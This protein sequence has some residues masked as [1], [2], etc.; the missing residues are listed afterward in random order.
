MIPLRLSLRN[1]MCFREG[2]PPLSFEGLHLLCLSGNNGN[3]KTALID[4]M[5]WALWGEA[6][7]KNPD[8]LIS[9]SQPEMEVDFE[10]A[11][12]ERTYRIIRKRARPRSQKASGV[13]TLDFQAATSGSYKSIAGNT[14]A[15]TQ[16]K[17]TD[18]L[19]MDYQTFT[20]SAYLRQGN[21]DEFTNKR[22]GERKEV[23][24]SIL[25]LSR[26]D[27][28]SEQAREQERRHKAE[29][30]QLQNAV[31]ELSDEIARKPEYE[32]ELKQSQDILNG[33]ETEMTVKTR[34]LEELRQRMETLG[35]MQVE[36]EQVES[37]M[38][39]TRG[40][41]E[42]WKEQARLRQS[43]IAAYREVIS[44]KN[45]IEEGF[46]RFS[47]AKEQFRNL[48]NKFRQSFNLERQKTQLEVKINEASRKLNNE[49]IILQREIDK[50]TEQS[51]GLQPLLNR[52]QSLR[53]KQ[54]GF[55]SREQSIREKE[56]EC[57]DFQGQ[58][59]R[60][61]AENA[62]LEEEIRELDEKLDLL[63]AKTEARCPLCET[64][65]GSEGLSIIR[66]KYES[67]RRVKAASLE[68]NL[69]TIGDSRSRLDTLREEAAGLQKA[70]G[71]ERLLLEG[72]IRVLD[73]NIRE[74]EDA[75]RKLEEARTLLSDIEQRLAGREYA[76]ADITALEEVTAAIS[77]L[78]YDE[79]EHKQAELGLKELEKYDQLKR[80]V[81]EATR[82]I[83][84]EN[85]ALDKAKTAIDKLSETLSADEVKLKLL[86]SELRILPAASEDL[87]MAETA[88]RDLEHRLRQA[89]ESL[90]QAKARLERCQEME[91]RK[92]EK[93]K[94]FARTA[95]EESIYRE[96]AEAF[97]KKGIQALLIEMAI[98]EIEEEA[99]RLLSRMTDNRMHLKFDTQRATRKG[100][101]SET[102]EINIAD[103]TNTRPYE[104]FSGGEAFRINFAIRI[105]LSRLLAK[106]AGAPLSTLIIDEGFGTQDSTGIE[107]LKEAI[108]SIKEDFQRI[109][110]ITHI[111][112]LRDSFMNRID[113]VKT[114][115]GSTF[116]VN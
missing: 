73:E 50:L 68:A 6:R 86:E 44:R 63:A 89:R 106:R 18:A 27:L 43:K 69:K 105:A 70:L 94:L 5:T 32:D 87:E 67:D 54:P 37:R 100:E 93:E 102:L 72:E 13:P 95:K 92:K 113:V 52:R 77:S 41:L 103:E 74:A 60:R 35:K 91:T 96:L 76:R 39:D 90:W 49:H 104:M 56:Q 36:L 79:A 107:K 59:N 80:K 10:F 4:A 19:H 26:Y 24:G 45:E 71:Q 14:V 34:Q 108:N 57:R 84:Q 97:G 15:E 61:E 40:N 38:R 20:N 115:E 23:L 111:E 47:Q 66:T 116:S 101:V 25:D 62:R 82:F 75:G 83:E 33:L 22:P 9:A 46:T 99:N 98:P 3:G 65:L 11:I 12:G 16:R 112:E 2:V 7:A 85:E 28:L 51:R 110:V 81:D 1:F 42:S 29:K 114:A 30:A 55:A 53:E 78:G 21:A 31:Q 88:S 64:E 58:L 109:I 8:D 17:I 48:D